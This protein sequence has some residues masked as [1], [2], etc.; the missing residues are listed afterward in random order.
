[1]NTELP[2]DDKPQEVEISNKR[3]LDGL[4]RMSGL[5]DAKD[6]ISKIGLKMPGI[7][8]AEEV[9][10][11]EISDSRCRLFMRLQVEAQK[12]GVDFSKWC[13]AGMKPIGDK[14]F[15]DFKSHGRT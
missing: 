14:W 6:I 4:Y 1:M 2:L 12:A 5:S 9:L 10:S 8:V 15:I 7:R 13:I 11:S 3:T